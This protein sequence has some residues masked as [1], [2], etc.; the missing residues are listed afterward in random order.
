MLPVWEIEIKIKETTDLK[1]EV[2]MKQLW[3]KNILWLALV[4]ALLC[5]TT[6]C[7]EP[8]PDIPGFTW[9]QG[10]IDLAVTPGEIG[11][12]TYSFSATIPAA[13][14]YTLYIS[15][16]SSSNANIIRTTGINMTVTPRDSSSPGIINNL[17][18]DTSYSIV[19]VAQK[20]DEETTSQ[21]V[22]ARTILGVGQL[23]GSISIELPE[24]VDAS[25][26]PIRT[27]LKAVYDGPEEDVT[28][29]WNKDYNILE[30]Q[31]QTTFTAEE[32]GVY[33]V[34][35][36]HEDFSSKTS[37]SVT[38]ILLPLS[39]SISI[40]IPQGVDADNVYTTMPLTA[41][42][43]GNETEVLFQWFTGNTAID[44]ATK[45]VF[46]PEEAGIYTVEVTADRFETK[47]SLHVNVKTFVAVIEISGVTEKITQNS[48]SVIGGTV[49][50]A[51]ASF[52]D[53]IW[54]LSGDNDNGSAY[55][56]DGSLITDEYGIITLTATILNGLEWGVDFTKDFIV[57]VVTY[58]MLSITMEE[59]D[60]GL[61]DVGNAVITSLGGQVTL[62]T[63]N[64]TVPLDI[65][66]DASSLG[67]TNI[68][69]YLGNIPLALNSTQYTLEYA[70][71]NN[72]GSY[73]L[74]I[75]FNK[76]GNRWS[77][78]FNFNVN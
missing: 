70:A 11:E 65:S 3:K 31:I 28:F 1:G 74:T 78:S 57:D 42:Y 71:F 22:S 60:F 53:I 19:I 35:V 63:D 51:D 47:T 16:G 36:S 58:V 37:S 46:T 66:A 14:T 77:G 68:D 34:T 4:M 24:G 26:I 15:L 56:E 52:K 49:V 50:P 40:D 30:N 10:I 54:E 39:G 75:F 59:H 43:D 67:L 69:W 76:D 17:E 27:M 45:E 38:V 20:G 5:V 2:K 7:P 55:I 73:T 12:L 13:D 41:R 44:D 21:I 23:S 62:S 32:P 8:Q 33:T 25:E 6:G 18:N 72:P 29:Q 9:E 61:S 48:P 64:Q